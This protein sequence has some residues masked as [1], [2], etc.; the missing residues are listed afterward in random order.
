MPRF[1]NIFMPRMMR[2]M[3]IDKKISPLERGRGV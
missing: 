3:S 2:V 1:M